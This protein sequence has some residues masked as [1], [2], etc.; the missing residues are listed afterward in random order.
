MSV[1]VGV[2]YRLSQL[3][4]KPTQFSLAGSAQRQELHG[5]VMQ[6]SIQDHHS[7]R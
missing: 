2:G 4:Y 6:P 5:G 3:D 7:K 1:L